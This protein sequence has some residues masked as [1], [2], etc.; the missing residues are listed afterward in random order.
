[1][2]HRKIQGNEG[3]IS[4]ETDMAR[5]KQ[6]DRLAHLEEIVPSDL[7]G[8]LSIFERDRVASGHRIAALEAR[9]AEMQETLVHLARG[10]VAMGYTRVIDKN[11]VETNYTPLFDRWPGNGS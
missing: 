5:P 6:E 8:V 1:M 4:H 9:M 3:N 11:G 10:E 7:T 2:L